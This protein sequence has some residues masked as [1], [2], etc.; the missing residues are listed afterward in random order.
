MITPFGEMD[1]VFCKG[2]AAVLFRVAENQQ[3]GER[4]KCEASEHADDDG[5]HDGFLSCNSCSRDED[6]SP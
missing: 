5:E 6:I 1:L 3:Y 2:V 4:Q